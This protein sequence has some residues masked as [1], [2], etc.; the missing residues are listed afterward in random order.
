MMRMTMKRNPDP[1][2]VRLDSAGD[3]EEDAAA[4]DD[5]E[6]DEDDDDD[7]DVA[8]DDEADDEEEFRQGICLS[9]CCCGCQG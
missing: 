2:F 8:D 3:A 4:A 7:D 5:D 6:D 9:G 1:E